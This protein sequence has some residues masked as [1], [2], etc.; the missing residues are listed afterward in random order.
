MK[1]ATKEH[2]LCDIILVEVQNREI[3]RH[4]KKKVGEGWGREGDS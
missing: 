1:P 3:Y 4:R 2:I